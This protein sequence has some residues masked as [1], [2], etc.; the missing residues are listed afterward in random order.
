MVVFL[1]IWGDMNNSVFVGTLEIHY[2]V[3]DNGSVSQTYEFIG[4]GVS[5]GGTWDW[6]DNGN[7]EI[8]LT[9]NITNKKCAEIQSLEKWTP[10]IIPPKTPWFVNTNSN[11]I[12]YQGPNNKKY[13]WQWTVK[14]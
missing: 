1:D 11:L 4:K 10:Y 6:V 5:D 3:W 12:F 9:S 7:I 8:H 13:L 2:F 14:N